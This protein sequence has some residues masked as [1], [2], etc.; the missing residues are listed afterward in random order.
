MCRSMLFCLF[1]PL[2][3][4]ASQL[5]FGQET[6]PS[7]LIVEGTATNAVTGAPLAGARVKLCGYVPSEVYART[8]AAGKYRFTAH[9]PGGYWLDSEQPGFLTLD[10]SHAHFSIDHSAMRPGEDGNMHAVVPMRLTAYAVIT[11]RVTGPDGLP[12][13]RYPVSLLRKCTLPPRA[14]PALVHNGEL[15]IPYGL[16]DHATGFVTVAFAEVLAAME[17]E[18][19]LPA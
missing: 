2:L 10:E 1:A 13:E 12:L 18:A 8:D 17:Q 6:P 19:P 7:T 4:I 14:S 15:I 5:C 16:A 11:G 9:F 3:P